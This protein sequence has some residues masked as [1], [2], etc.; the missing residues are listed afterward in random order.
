MTIEK[1]ENEF[2]DAQSLE[3]KRELI[4]KLLDSDIDFNDSEIKSKLKEYSSQLQDFKETME[5]ENSL[6]IDTDIENGKYQLYTCIEETEFFTKYVK[7]RN[8]YV[9]IDDISK[10]Y[11]ENIGDITDL[12]DEFKE[13]LSN[14]NPVVWIVSDDGIGTLKRKYSFSDDFSKHFTIFE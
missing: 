11:I 2:N 5:I 1:F 14:I 10:R 4:E 8:Y 7:G 6:L 3:L 12:N 13:Y 9:S